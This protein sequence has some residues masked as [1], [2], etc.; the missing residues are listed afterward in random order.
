LGRIAEIG[1]LSA[2]E[3]MFLRLYIKG[4]TL[5]EAYRKIHEGRIDAKPI[6]DRS[7]RQ[8]GS[9]MLKRI[10]AKVDWPRLMES[11]GLGEMRVLR[12]IEARLG[13]METHFY[14]D[15]VVADREDNG[16]RMR[17]TELLADFHGK[18][19]NQLEVSGPGGGPLHYVLSVADEAL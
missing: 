6:S 7:I 14:Q 12:E 17:A 13:A 15:K 8:S 19:K 3:S 10:K 2:R 9:N 18:R 1:K 11:A 16:T 4:A 5:E